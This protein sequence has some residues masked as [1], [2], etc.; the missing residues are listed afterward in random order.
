MT[1][2]LDWG[3]VPSWAS[4]FVSLLA[5]CSAVFA[6]TQAWRALKI[7]QAGDRRAEAELRK[8]LDE[9]QR[10]QAAKVS[11]WV[12]MVRDSTTDTAIANVRN[13]SELPV[14][15]LT[16]QICLDG[17]MVETLDAG[18]LPPNSE[19]L[20]RPLTSSGRSVDRWGVTLTFRDS[21]GLS[22]HRGQDGALTKVNPVKP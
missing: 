16:A 8:R 18:V 7:Q 14:Y 3:N 4:A 15:D 1:Q 5:L 10:A 12:S 9:E 2:G 11:A 17:R 22:W 13:A 6:A 21:A 19:P 20:R